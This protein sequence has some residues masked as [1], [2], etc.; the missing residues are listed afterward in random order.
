MIIQQA[1][2]K[3]FLLRKPSFTFGKRFLIYY[4]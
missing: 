3:K 4:V 2:F 1:E